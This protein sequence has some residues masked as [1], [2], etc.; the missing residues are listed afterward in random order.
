MT[1][2]SQVHRLVDILWLGQ[3]SF[4]LENGIDIDVQG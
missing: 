2:Q 3:I 4:D 1:G